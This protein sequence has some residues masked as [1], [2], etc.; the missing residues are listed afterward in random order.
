M[1]FVWQSLQAI[2]SIESTLAG[3]AYKLE[4]SEGSAPGLIFFGGFINCI[5]IKQINKNTSIFLIITKFISVMYKTNIKRAYPVLYRCKKRSILN[6]ILLKKKDKLLLALLAQV[7][8]PV[9]FRYLTFLVDELLEYK[10]QIKKATE[11]P[12]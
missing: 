6:H 5:T 3:T 9:H 8:R 2:V 4:M 12:I 10:M 1:L 7:S 11:G